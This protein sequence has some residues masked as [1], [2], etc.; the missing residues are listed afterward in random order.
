MGINRILENCHRKE[1]D[2]SINDLPSAAD[3]PEY[4]D[5]PVIRA[6]NRMITLVIA[7]FLYANG[8][9]LKDLSEK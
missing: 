1:A 8:F 9:F 3:V 6:I 5:R 4:T 2:I 7:I